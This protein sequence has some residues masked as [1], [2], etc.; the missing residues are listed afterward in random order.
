MDLSINALLSTVLDHKLE[1]CYCL[2]PRWIV[3]PKLPELL[4]QYGCFYMNGR[5]HHVKVGP[6]HIYDDMSYMF[7]PKKDMSVEEADQCY[8]LDESSGEI[9]PIFFLVKCGRCLLCQSSKLS[10][11]SHRCVLESQMYSCDPI[12]ITLTYDDNHLPENGN[13]SY[14]D[15]KNFKKRFSINLKRHGLADYIRVVDASEYGEK[16]GRPHYHLIVWNLDCNDMNRFLRVRS[17]CYLSWRRCS[18]FV[19]R[20]GFRLINDQYIP[21]GQTK[22]LRELGVSPEKVF[23]YVAAYIGKPNSLEG[24]AHT[25]V[26]TPRGK[27][28]G[29][30]APFLD[31]HMRQIR[32]LKHTKF[33]FRDSRSGKLLELQYDRYVLNRCFPSRYVSVPYLFRKN[34]LRFARIMPFL[35]SVPY[36]RIFDN[37]YSEFSKFFFIPKLQQCDVT[38]FRDLKTSLSFMNSSFAT[39]I[40]DD[41]LINMSKFWDRDFS[42]VLELENLR[43]VVLSSLFEVKKPRDKIMEVYKLKM[44][45]YVKSRFRSL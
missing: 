19:L 43:H 15:I 5:I 35:P 10:S 33:K 16:S 34:L 41:C 23:E 14:S 38:H 45:D 27:R 21:K 17:L 22:S 13:V 39:T 30:G 9:F 29:L 31:A 40:A 44:R 42:S 7:K 4:I 18:S 1:D 8:V 28:G 6:Y 2:E 26:H 37:L 20:K 12:H 36:R 32:R 25:W 3:N 11:F 24:K